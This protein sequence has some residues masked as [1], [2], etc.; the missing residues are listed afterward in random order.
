MC[1][2][3]FAIHAGGSNEERLDMIIDSENSGV[4]KHLG[5]IADSM[6]KWEGKIAEEL[7]LSP[8]DVAAIKTEHPS[9][10]RL[11]MYDI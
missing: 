8:A 10:L 4:L 11:Q 7:K 3:Y 9:N 5:K 2:L 1:V 6:D